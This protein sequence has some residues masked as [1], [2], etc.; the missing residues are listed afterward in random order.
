MIL[1]LI[2]G[3]GM[4]LN[5][6]GMGRDIVSMIEENLNSD[7]KINV[8]EFD[9]KFD[10]DGFIDWLNM[11]DKMLAFKKYTGQRAVTLVETKETKLTGYIVLTNQTTYELVR[12]RR[13][14]YLRGIPERIYPFSKGICT[15]LYNFCCARTSIYNLE[16]L[17]TTQELEIKSR[18]YTCLDIVSCRCC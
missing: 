12:R 3:N 9:G 11:V 16:P 8:P 17:P 5:S 14:P 1:Q 15:N 13:I 10:G 2:I 4:I 6:G 18:P 7:V